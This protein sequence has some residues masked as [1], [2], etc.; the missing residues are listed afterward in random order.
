MNTIT[1][2]VYVE[3][4]QRSANPDLTVTIDH[5]SDV[6]ELLWAVIDNS[7]DTAFWFHAFKTKQEAVEFCNKMRWK[8][9]SVS[10]DRSQYYTD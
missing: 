2:N 9:T 1:E 3:A 8:I 10:E 7:D 6:G 4:L 5:N